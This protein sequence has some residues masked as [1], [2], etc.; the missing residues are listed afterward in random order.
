MDKTELPNNNASKHYYCVDQVK[1]TIAAIHREKVEITSE[2]NKTKDPS[3][4][5]TY[6]HGFGI[7]LI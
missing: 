4:S 5:L 7:F 2:E 1:S 3:F 6:K